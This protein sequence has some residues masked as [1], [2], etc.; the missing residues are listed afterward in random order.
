[1]STRAEFLLAIFALFTFSA[2]RA[3]DATLLV[4]GEV[5]TPLKLS[6]AEIKSLP[7][8]TVSTKDHSGN[9]V[10]YEGVPLTEL[11]HRAGVPQGEALR[12]N[13]LQLCLMAKAA[14]G[15]KV[16]FTLAELDSAST[17]RPVLLA[18]RR[19]GAELDATAGPL[20]II[21]PDEK[22]QARWVRQVTELEVIR[23]DAAH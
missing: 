23:V 4:R 5:K 1:M 11:L 10:R 16:V 12:G 15:Y 19:D 13:A 2:A 9:T 18:F 14:D 20:R 7:S 8:A 22:R 17:D 3:A 6:L 21:V